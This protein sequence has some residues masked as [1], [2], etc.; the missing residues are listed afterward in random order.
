[1]LGLTEPIPQ[2]NAPS[3][4]LATPLHQYTQ[5]GQHLCALIMELDSGC[6]RLATHL[7]MLCNT[8]QRT[9]QAPQDNVH[10]SAQALAAWWLE[11]DKQPKI[12][13]LNSALERASRLIESLIKL[14][15]SRHK[16]QSIQVPPSLLAMNRPWFLLGQMA[17]GLRHEVGGLLAAMR[18]NLTFVLDH[19]HSLLELGD[20][21]EGLSNGD[22]LEQWQLL[23]G[24][25]GMQECTQALGET[26]QLNQRLIALCTD[27]LALSSEPTTEHFELESC[28]EAALRLARSSISKQVKIHAPQTL[29]HPTWIAGNPRR[30]LRDILAL[31]VGI[32]DHLPSPQ[33]RLQVHTQLVQGPH[34]HAL[35]V[36]VNHALE[37]GQT[38]QQEPWMDGWLCAVDA[39]S[40]TTFTQM[41]TP[42]QHP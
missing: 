4:I 13:R 12:S 17:T 11:T 36:R 38:H 34:E 5:S 19:T 10:H 26:D 8:A 28:L 15:P 6:H 33:K 27:V 31:L 2:H 29:T 23:D 42:S 20:V 30:L 22:P 25:D 32:N 14:L 24:I 9:A 35:S 41:L 7:N 18:A 39:Q 21:L 3:Q 16:P 1:M 40:G 37:L